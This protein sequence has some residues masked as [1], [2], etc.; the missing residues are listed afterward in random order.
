MES[1]RYFDVVS[2]ISI[3]EIDEVKVLPVREICLTDAQCASGVERILQYA[4]KNKVSRSRLNEVIEKINGLKSFPGVE[5]LASFFYDEKESLFDYFSGETLLVWDEPELINGKCNH[6]HE[7][8]SEEYSRCLERGDIAVS[9]D[10]IYVGSDAIV[11]KMKF[12]PHLLLNTLKLAEAGE[13][14]TVQVEVQSIPAFQNKVDHF[15]A[16]AAKWLE[17]GIKVVVAAPT[18]GHVRRLNE[19]LVEQEMSLVVEQG[20]ISSGFMLPAQNKV[21]VA[22]HEIFGQVH[23]H[24]YRRKPRSQSF[25]RGFKDLKEGD[26]LVHV[27][28]GMV[29][30]WGRRKFRP[31]LEVANFLKF[32]MMKNKNFIFPWRVWPTFKNFRVGGMRNPSLNKLGGTQWKRQKKKV[33]E[34]IREMAEGLLKIYAARKLAKRSTYSAEPVIMQEFA[35][36]FEYVETDDQLNAIEEVFRGSGGR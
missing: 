14:Q 32:Y 31:V 13:E 29:N 8:V 20:Q 11:R 24:R 9:P 22:E 28:Y 15:M 21:F 27:D 6:F 30:T 3:E 26:L 34:S 35:D 12:D 18:K 7:L 4:Q 2:Q 25:Q 17:Q 23:K 16:T 33:K 36:S 10:D 5:T 19:L 1:L